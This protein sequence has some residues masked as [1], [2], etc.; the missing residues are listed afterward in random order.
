MTTELDLA[1]QLFE[2]QKD[3]R[4]DVDAAPFSTLDRAAAYRIQARVL[5]MLG[6]KPALLKTLIAADGVGVAAPI[7]GSRVG[8]SG[9]YRTSAKTV[10]GLEVEV[11]LVLAHDL[12]AETAI[13]DEAAIADA[14]DHYFVGVEI[15]GRRYADPKLA[16]PN[17]PLADGASAYGY[18]INPK[19][20]EFGADIENFDVALE[21]NGK[22]IH[23]GPAK[24]SFGT[25]LASFLAYAKAQ[26]P[27]YPLRA[28]TVITT[29]S[30]C[31]MV[32]V[33]GPGHAIARF[34]SHEVTLDLI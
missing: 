15:C 17:G 22:Q 34:G 14:I 11:G 24:H 16:G 2:A 6:E 32:P 9:S 31:G 26:Y 1:Q 30:L 25:V 18:V 13:N 3:G 19:P 33:S 23:A 27:A 20:R 21:F 7:Y 8:Q 10:T 5:D 12:S 4:Q 28:G 29:G